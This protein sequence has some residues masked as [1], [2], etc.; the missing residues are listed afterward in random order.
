VA[1]KSLVEWLNMLWEIWRASMWCDLS[2]V[3][4][5]CPFSCVVVRR[6]HAAGEFVLLL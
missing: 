5:L 6:P 1:S 4:L 3:V 2:R